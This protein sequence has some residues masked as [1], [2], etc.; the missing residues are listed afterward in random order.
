MARVNVER[1]EM[2]GEVKLGW[3]SAF[4]FGASPMQR[5]VGRH[6]KC[7]MTML[8]S[9]GFPSSMLALDRDLDLHLRVALHQQP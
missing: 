3:A 1:C 8:I 7:A 5:R 9:V 6:Q 4:V 2:K